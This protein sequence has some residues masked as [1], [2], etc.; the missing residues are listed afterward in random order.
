MRTAPRRDLTA[1]LTVALMATRNDVL[2]DLRGD[3]K[4]RHLG[5]A[6]TALNTINAL[7]ALR[8]DHPDRSHV[9]IWE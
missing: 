2:A 7:Q 1:H 4:R 9:Q 3:G 6:V 5:T 8:Q